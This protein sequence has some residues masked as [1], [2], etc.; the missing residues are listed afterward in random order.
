MRREL[1]HARYGLRPHEATKVVALVQKS[2]SAYRF[3]NSDIDVSL[4]FPDPISLGRSSFNVFSHQAAQGEPPL[5]RA[6]WPSAA[7]VCKP[8]PAKSEGIFR[9]MK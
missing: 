8:K 3:S 7:T 4:M 2:R 9:P 5:Y 6:V 1:G